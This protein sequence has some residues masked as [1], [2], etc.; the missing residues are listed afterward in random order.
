MDLPFYYDTT[1]PSN[2][3]WTESRGK[4][5]KAGQV[6]WQRRAQVS[7][8][9]LDTG[10]RY[11]ST[12]GRVVWILHHG[13]IEGSMRIYFKDGDVSNTAIENLE[14]VTP[15]RYGYLTSQRHQKRGIKKHNNRWHATISKMGCSTYI[16]S[17]ATELEA[18]AA[19]QQAIQEALNA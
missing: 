5:V 13:P 18:T 2:I 14:L 11:Y 3:R 15:Q 16:G 7:W 8:L 19:H 9:D 17:Y 4:V 10:E 12:I 1:S 6:A